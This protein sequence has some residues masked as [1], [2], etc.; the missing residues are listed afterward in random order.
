VARREREIATALQESAEHRKASAKLREVMAPY[1]GMLRS[2]GSNAFTAIGSLMQTAQAL[3]TAPPQHKAQLVAQLVSQFGVDIG[4]LD[5]A[6]SGQPVPGGNQR[7]QVD[8]RQL[9][10]EEFAALRA[11]AEADRNAQE[12]SKNQRETEAFAEDHEFI[13][14][15]RGRMA[16]L[17]EVNAR[18]NIAMSLQEAYDEACRLHPEV[19]KVIQ[20]REAAKAAA[21]GNSATQRSKI[22]SSS[23]RSQPT[24]GVSDKGSSEGIRGDLLSAAGKFDW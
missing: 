9:V 8:P 24:S 1:E 23:V 2:E 19:S 13:D 15:V 14:D 3:R 7:Q 22:A 6:L 20:Q 17:L 16:T 4:M 10:R 12:F 18:E 21:T 5:A 11:Q